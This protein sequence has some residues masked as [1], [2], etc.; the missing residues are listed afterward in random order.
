MTNPKQYQNSNVPNCLA[1][2]SLELGT[3]LEFGNWNF[4]ITLFPQVPSVFQEAL[5]A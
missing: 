4:I 3:Y 1:V 5:K 2:W